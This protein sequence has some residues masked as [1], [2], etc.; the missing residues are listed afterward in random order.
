MQQLTKSALAKVYVLTERLDDTI[1]NAHVALHL[2]SAQLFDVGSYITSWQQVADP[3]ARHE[4]LQLVLTLGMSLDGL[5]RKPDLR[6]FLKLLPGQRRWLVWEG[7]V[8]CETQLSELLT[9]HTAI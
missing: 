5:T 8:A 9:V 3:L 7:A 6:M 4:Q 2:A 1:T